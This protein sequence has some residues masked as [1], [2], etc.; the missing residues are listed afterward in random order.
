MGGSL[1]YGRSIN[2]QQFIN[3]VDANWYDYETGRALQGIPKNEMT[4]R[5]IVL[6]LFLGFSLD[7]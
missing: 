7:F 3:F 2:N 6:G 4:Y 1:S 5:Y